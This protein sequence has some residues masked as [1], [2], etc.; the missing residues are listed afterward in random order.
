MRNYGLFAYSTLASDINETQTTIELSDATRFDNSNLTENFI[1]ICDEEVMLCTS[2]SGTTCTVIRGYEGTTATSHSAGTTIK[3]GPVPSDITSLVEKISSPSGGKVVISKTDGNIE[4]SDFSSSDLHSPNTDNYLDYGGANQVSASEIKTHIQNSSNP[5]QTSLENLTD[6][7]ISSPTNGQ[8]LSYNETSGK[9]ENSDVVATSD[10]KVKVSSN[11]TTAGYLNGKLV[12]GDGISLIE[13]NDGGDETL[14]IDNTDKGSSAVS[15][16]E[17]SYDHSLLHTQNTDQYLDQGGANQVSASE[18]RTH[19][20]DTN[21]PHNVTKSQIGLENV[22][23]DAQ[24]KR[25]AGDFN[26]FPE[27]TSKTNDDILLIED[28]EDSYN[29]KKISVETLLSGILGIPGRSVE[30]IVDNNGN[31]IVDSNNDAIITTDEIYIGTWT[32]GSSTYLAVYNKTDN[33]FNSV[34]VS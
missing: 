33:T 31:I 18:I 28:S 23:N 13:N 19:I 1:L 22:T 32:T 10:E 6:T 30:F 25:S 14:T 15:T 9:W 29:K 27:K 34:E 11:D 24:L 17:S 21:N 4:E 12:A 26:S 2:R 3:H 8:V 16:H 20:D 7:N 5:H